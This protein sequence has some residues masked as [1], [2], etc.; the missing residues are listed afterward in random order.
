MAKNKNI[1]IP[2]IQRKFKINR[3]KATTKAEE[4]GYKFEKKSFVSIFTDECKKILC[5]RDVVLSE[6]INTLRNKLGISRR[7]IAKNTDIP[8]LRYCHLERGGVEF[9]FP[10]EVDKISTFWSLPLEFVTI[11]AANELQ[12][13]R[14]EKK[15]R[16]LERE[17]QKKQK[18]PRKY[19]SRIQL[20]PE[21]Y[22]E[23]EEEEEEEDVWEAPTKS[24][25]CKNEER[26]SQNDTITVAA[27][28]QPK[29][30]TFSKFFTKG[31]YGI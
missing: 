7:F 18:K 26:F 11:A 31:G 1:S 19:V 27:T 30:R 28:E 10:E 20:E 5:K 23:D 8:Y 6:V 17:Q 24:I 4:L 15:R 14:K 9:I 29:A 25:F 2:L 16:R 12:E 13:R 21:D 22:E 3:E